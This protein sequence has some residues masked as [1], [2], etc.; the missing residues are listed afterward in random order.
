M[1]DGTGNRKTKT[2]PNGITSYE[3]NNLN[4]LMSKSGA[5]GNIS[6]QY[7]DKGELTVKGGY[8]FDWNT[9][10]KIKKVT[11]PDNSTVEFIYDA[12][13]R[14]TEK[15]A[16]SAAG[17]VTRHLKYEYEDATGNLLVETDVLAN[18]KIAYSYNI[19]GGLISQTQGGKTYYYNYDGQGNVVSLTDATGNVVASYMY[20]PWGEKVRLG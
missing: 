2:A 13:G 20:D 16:K 3:Y 6:Y 11:K 4:Q 1:Y 19:N 10:G 12:Q 14:R 15:I 17:T 9:D 18:S 5:D 7:N 8:S